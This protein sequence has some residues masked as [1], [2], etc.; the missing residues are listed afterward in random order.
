MMLQ[1]IKSFVK[2]FE[3]CPILWLYRNW[4]STVFYTENPD[5]AM[6]QCEMYQ[7]LSELPRANR[8][9]IAFIMLHLLR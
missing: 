5:K 9:T 2:P 6:S 4:F 1:S 7:A 3:L 8:D